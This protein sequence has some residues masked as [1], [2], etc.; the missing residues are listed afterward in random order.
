MKI[1]IRHVNLNFKGKKPTARR[2]TEQQ[3]Q[4]WFI[5]WFNYMDFYKTTCTTSA[6]A[7]HH[8]DT[9]KL[10]RQSFA[11]YRPYV[12]NTLNVSSVQKVK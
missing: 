4:R 10:I 12:F 3:W 9:D 11:F 1:I 8:I 2:D 6:G 7:K 5:V